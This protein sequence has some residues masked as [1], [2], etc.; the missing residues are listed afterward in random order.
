MIGRKALTLI[1]AVVAALF[2]LT[3]CG[4][5]SPAPAPGQ[6]AQQQAPGPGSNQDNS[7]QADTSGQDDSDDD[8]GWSD[9]DAAIL[10]VESLLG[11][12]NAEAQVD[13]DG[14]FVLTLDGDAYAEIDGT[15]PC[16]IIW[17]FVDKNEHPARLIYP[18]GTIEC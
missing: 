17:Q 3:A 8:G 1:A 13:P 2:G 16:G 6:N 7:Q 18:N 14:T 5:G 4:G 10:F 11:A 12:F 15:A 9:L